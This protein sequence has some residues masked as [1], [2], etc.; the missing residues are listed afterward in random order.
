[1]DNDTR[2]NIININHTI[3]I[4]VT[5]NEKNNQYTL[6]LVRAALS[7]WSWRIFPIGMRKIH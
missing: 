1:M 4:Y 6:I 5:R 2:T 7:F 3:T